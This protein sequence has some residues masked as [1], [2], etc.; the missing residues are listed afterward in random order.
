MTAFPTVDPVAL[1][2]GRAVRAIYG[3]LGLLV[4]VA[5][6]LHIGVGSSLWISPA[7][8]IAEVL[9][10]NRGGAD[11]I[12]T[13]VWEIRLPRAAGCLLV[14]ALLGLVG[15]AFQALFRNPL[16]EPYVV[17]VSSG[18]AV[19][20]SLALILRFSEAFFGLAGLGTAFAGGLG[21]LGLVVALAKR[22]GVI[23][24]PTLLL[25]GVV[26]GSLLAALL[27]LIL[28]AAGGDTNQV[29]RWLLGSMTPMFWPRLSILCVTLLAGVTIL[30]R[31]T[32]R[33]NAFAV[34]E[35]SAQRLGVDTSRLKKRVLVTGTAMAA[36]AV[37]SVGIVGFLGLVAPHI[38][39]RLLGIDLRHSLI[40]AGLLGSILLLLADLLAQRAVPGTELPVGAVTAV[41]GAPTLLLLLRGKGETP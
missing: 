10:G 11:P 25:A 37:G 28:L 38:A 5:L 26:V 32:R 16:A 4:F 39:R 14:G 19:G 13:V 22:R 9:G 34:G 3:G 35:D 40:G 36:V 30:A 23:N 21:S 31:E 33:L 1:P 20:G 2:A 41:L 17:G 15:A 27:S 8:V 18:A 24:V 29:L 7:R 6:V 12:N